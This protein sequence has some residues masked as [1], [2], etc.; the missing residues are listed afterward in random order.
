MSTS[1]SPALVTLDRD[2]PIAI[3]RIN[4]PP[5]NLLSQD[6]RQQLGDAFATLKRDNAVR[7]AV[8]ASGDKNFC[9]GA[10]MKEFPLRFDPVV[11]EAHW[12]RAYRMTLNL[13]TLEKPTIAAIEGACFGGGMELALSCDRRICAQGSKLGLP[14]I[15]RGI[16]PGSSGMLLLADLVGRQRAKQVIM[17]GVPLT[18]AHAAALDVVNEICPNGDA[19]KVAL[20]VACKLAGQSLSGLSAIKRLIDATFIEQFVARAEAE[21]QAFIACYQTA[22]AREGNRAFFE[23]REPSWQHR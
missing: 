7:V 4:R 11:A 22:D 12:H 2:G 13:L 20:G 5:L 14:E 19:L 18:P 23:K 21:R 10:D 9:A 17:D 8:L 3:V 16:F 6:V 1:A 15:N